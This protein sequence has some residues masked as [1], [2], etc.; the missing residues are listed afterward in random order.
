M[1]LSEPTLAIIFTKSKVENS[2]S[3]FIIESAFSNL[4]YACDALKDIVIR[5]QN[6]YWFVL[7]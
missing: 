6:N 1:G 4:K 5:F 3:Q 7:F 2:S